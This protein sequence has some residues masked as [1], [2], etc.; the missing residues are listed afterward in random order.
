MHQT[1]DAIP[2]LHERTERHDLGDAAVDELIDG[3]GLGKCLPRV[4]LC[5]LKR[6]A[7]ALTVAIDLQHLDI[8]FVA[9]S[10]DFVGVVDELP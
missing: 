3:V 9:N 5:C 8:N 7:D 2:H 10:D 1:F 4:L 6:Q